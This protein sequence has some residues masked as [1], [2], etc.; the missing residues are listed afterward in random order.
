MTQHIFSRELLT[1]IMNSLSDG[2][3]WNV[4]TDQSWIE[5][6]LF[7]WRVIHILS[8]ENIKLYFNPSRK[9]SAWL[10]SKS[11]IPSQKQMY[12]F[13]W[14]KFCYESE[15]TNVIRVKSDPSTLLIN[16]Q[17]HWKIGLNIIMFNDIFLFQLDF[18]KMCFVQFPDSIHRFSTTRGLF[19]LFHL[20]C[21]WSDHLEANER[22]RSCEALN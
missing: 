22:C 15:K 9:I 16:V 21:C 12:G 13:V 10:L 4:P 7:I 14:H 8:D 19:H 17:S 2:F 3:L 5:L 11:S 20:F 6:T 1:N 18:K